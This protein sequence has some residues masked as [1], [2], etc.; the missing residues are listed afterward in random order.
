MRQIYFPGFLE[1]IAEQAEYLAN[2]ANADLA[3]RFIEAVR[4]T[5]NQ[6][7]RSPYLGFTREFRNAK[8]KN[9]RVWRVRDFEKYLIF[10][11]PRKES[12]DFLY[13]IY[14]ARDYIRL[15]DDE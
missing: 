14:S 9:V 4:F 15:F 8:L 11:V 1:S 10:Y 13:L 2:E 3:E 12:V 7:E 6:I 5:T